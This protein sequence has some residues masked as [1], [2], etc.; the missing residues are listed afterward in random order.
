MSKVLIIGIGNEFRQDDGIGILIARKI[1]LMNLPNI[2]V[3]EASGEGSELIEMW[4]GKS[5]V[6][7]VDA[8][9]SGKESGKI[10]YFDA[11]TQAPPTKFFN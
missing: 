3:H 10:Y 4:K 7:I 5:S 8:V 11:V 1:K 6:I 2:E 9:N